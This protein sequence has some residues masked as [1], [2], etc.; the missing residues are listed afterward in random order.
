MVQWQ[1]KSV[2][3]PQKNKNNHCVIYQFTYGYIPQIVENRISK[4]YLYTH[5]HSCLIHNRPKVEAAHCASTV[6]K[7][8]VVCAYNKILFILTKERNIDMCTIWMHHEEIILV[9]KSQKHKYYMLL[10]I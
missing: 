8:N 6:G 5:V 1:W 3:G 7:K 2:V 10:L 9:S 4:R